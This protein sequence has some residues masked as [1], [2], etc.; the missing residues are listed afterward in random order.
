VHQDPETLSLA[1]HQEKYVVVNPLFPNKDDPTSFAPSKIKCLCR[2]QKGTNGS[3]AK[4]INK[5]MHP[6]SVDTCNTAKLNGCL[7]SL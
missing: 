7:S 2:V 6:N 1:E 5:E 4:T 3:N